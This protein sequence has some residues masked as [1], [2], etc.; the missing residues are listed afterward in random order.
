MY[1]FI[2]MEGSCGN[3]YDVTKCEQHANKMA[4]EG[5]ATP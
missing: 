3:P 2:T 4:G 1:K 5:Y